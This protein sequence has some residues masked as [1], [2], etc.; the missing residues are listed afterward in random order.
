MNQGNCGTCPDASNCDCFQ[1]G[2]EQANFFKNIL[3]HD[4]N[5]ILN[6]VR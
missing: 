5:N 4:M 2:F 3:I 1:K 6:N